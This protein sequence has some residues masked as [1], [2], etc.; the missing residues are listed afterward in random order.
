MAIKRI[1]TG[2]RPTGPLHLGHYAGALR[3]WVELQQERIY[4]CFFLIADVQALT[5][6]IDRPKVIEGAVKEV[7]LDFI[8]VGLDPTKK[9]THFVLQSGIPE[10]TELTT[11]FSMLIPFS[12][13]E[14]NPTIKT[15]LSNLESPP[16]AGFMIYP[17]SQAAD[18]LLF[19]PYPNEIGDSLLVPVGNDQVPHIEGAADIARIF[20]NRYGDIFLKCEAKVGLVGRLVGTDG[21]AKMSKSLGNVIQLK[22]DTKTVNTTVMSMYTDPEKVRMGDSGHPEQCPVYTYHQ[23]FGLMDT[24]EE[25]AEGCRSGKLGCVECK[26]DLVSSLNNFLDPIRVRRKDA[27]K[28]LLGDYLREGTLKAREISKVTIEAVRQ[29]MHLTYPSIFENTQRKQHRKE[30]FSH[31]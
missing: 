20:N 4:E 18:V 14:K 6:H 11:Y 28:M 9:N 2:I 30:Y 23:V 22:D 21:R 15:E 3:M 25:R 27:E 16:T 12:R 1:L 26:K 7:V 24:L 19:T 17:I 13:M 29:A 31:D 10:L 8:A 5:T